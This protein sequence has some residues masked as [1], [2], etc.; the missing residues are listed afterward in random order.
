MDKSPATFEVRPHY[1]LVIGQGTRN[2]LTDMSNG[3]TFIYGKALE[4]KS[5]NLL[6][7]FRKLKINVPISDAYNIVRGYETAQPE[8]RNLKIAAVFSKDGMEFG[9]YWREIASKRGFKI[10]LF[11]SFERAES[12]LLEKGE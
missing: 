11:E 9:K 8:L 7:D 5:K 10:E 4:T 1:L 3:A 2:T 12:W 6:V